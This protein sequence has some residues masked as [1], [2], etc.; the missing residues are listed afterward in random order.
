MNKFFLVVLFLLCAFGSDAQ[1][2][3]VFFD[4]KD[5][6]TADSAKAKSYAIYGK[7]TGDSVYVFK[8][9]DLDGYLLV[10]GS[11]SDEQ[12]NVAH[13]KF[14]YYDWINPNDSFANLEAVSKGKERYIV[15]SGSFKN[16]HREGQWLSFYEN[17]DVKNVVIYKNNI[18]NGPYKFFDTKGNLEESGQF[19]NGKKEGEWQLDGGRKVA[20]YK[21]DKMIS[22]VKKTKKEIKAAKQTKP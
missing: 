6:V 5:K 20:I 7:V 11:F 17:G 15:L 8:K 2:K 22:V 18:L 13:G 9:Y 21:D 19:I 4:S 3:T 12:L 16:G 14:V 1:V 10:S